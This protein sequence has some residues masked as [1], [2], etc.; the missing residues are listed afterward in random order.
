M[1]RI[2]IFLAIVV[3]LAV[4]AALFFRGH[5]EG[6]A[7]FK[8]A[9]AKTEKE[10][11]LFELFEAGKM[12]RHIRKMQNSRRPAKIRLIGK[13][14]NSRKHEIIK[15]EE[16]EPDARRGFIRPEETGEDFSAFEVEKLLE[17]LNSG[18]RIEQR[19]AA[20]ALWDRY[21]ASPS[22]LTDAEK[23]AIAEAVARYLGG[24]KTDFEESFMQLQRLWHLAAPAL[25]ANVT[26]EDASV[27]ENAARLLSVMK[28]ERIIEGLIAESD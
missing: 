5:G 3:L 6:V 27:S 13:M 24:M 10:I 17:K 2:I 9:D 20:N 19:K 15:K 25:L 26:A 23:G 18:D 8:S 16:N 12:E 22:K 7:L 28:T 1:K 21:G 14:Q 11:P 4:A